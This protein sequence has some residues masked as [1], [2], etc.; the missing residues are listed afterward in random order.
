VIA[1]KDEVAKKEKRNKYSKNRQKAVVRLQQAWMD[2]S[3]QNNNFMHQTASSLVKSEY[4]SFGMENL[5]IPNMLKNNRLARS[6]SEASWSKFKVILSYKAESAGKGE[7]IEVPAQ[8]TT[9][10]CSNCHNVRKGNDKLKLKDRVYNCFVCGFIM[11]R[12]IN[13][14]R[15]ILHR[16]Q[17]IE[18]R[19][20]AGLARSN[21][22]G[23]VAST[24]QRRLDLQTTSVN[25]EH[26][27]AP[28]ELNPSGAEEANDF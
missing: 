22:F 27:L 8:D 3:N 20:R 17:K 21:A 5:Q 10:E 15:V 4:T 16:K 12:D 26:T 2:I 11:D 23:D 28:S 7:V 9:Q 18:E 25:Q 1:R 6:I 14:S 19:G 24:I 13:A